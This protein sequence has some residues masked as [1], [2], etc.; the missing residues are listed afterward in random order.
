MPCLKDD[1]EGK[2]APSL[3]KKLEHIQVGGR[4]RREMQCGGRKGRKNRSGGRQGKK[5]THQQ[6]SCM[7]DA[8]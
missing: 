3:E 8:W 1:S 5:L 6:R 7:S 4:Q 2:E